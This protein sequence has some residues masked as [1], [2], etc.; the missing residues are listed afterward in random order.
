M[1]LFPVA[2]ATSVQVCNVLVEI[3]IMD[4]C[5]TPPFLRCWT[6]D[7]FIFRLFEI[8]DMHHVNRELS[9]EK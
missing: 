3:K 7:S 2:V 6:V 4:R 8:N 9:N 1:Q 5:A